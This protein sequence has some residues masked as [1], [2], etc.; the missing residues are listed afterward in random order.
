MLC[1]SIKILHIYKKLKKY[2]TY[3][4]SPYI[5]LNNK[6]FLKSGGQPCDWYNASM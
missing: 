5:L 4:Y 6:T 2:F 1:L 3:K